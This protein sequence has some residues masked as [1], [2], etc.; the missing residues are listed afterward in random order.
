LNHVIGT[1]AISWAYVISMLNMVVYAMRHCVGTDSARA[2]LYK[3]R[4]YEAASVRS[5]TKSCTGVEGI[6]LAKPRKYLQLLHN[7][8]AARAKR[9][10]GGSSC[11][12]ATGYGLDQN[13]DCVWFALHHTPYSVLKQRIKDISY[14]NSTHTAAELGSLF[15]DMLT[16]IT[17]ELCKLDVLLAN[18]EIDA[19]RST[20][21]SNVVVN[22]QR[23]VSV[24]F[25]NG[26]GTTNTLAWLQKQH[27]PSMKQRVFGGFMSLIMGETSL[28]LEE[29]NYPE[30]VLLDISYIHTARGVFYGQ[31]AQATVLVIIGQ[32]LTDAGING[33]SVNKCLTHLSIDPVF[34]AF[35]LPEA[36]RQT[37]E[38]Q[39]MLHASVCDALNVLSGSTR[40]CDSI[41]D[42]ILWEMGRETTHRAYPTSNIA[43]SIARKWTAA[44]AMAVPNGRGDSPAVFASPETTCDGF[45]SD[46][47]LPNAA[48]F[49]SR[50]FYLSTMTLVNRVV[51]NMAVHSERYRELSHKLTQR[52][53]A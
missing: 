10:G 8:Y 31:V 37:K 30:L 6:L 23:K 44:T 35:G 26:L 13:G 15:C 32:R 53:H 7:T 3:N 34:V 42:L 45:V 40:V 38:T 29:I 16:A 50:E 22:E 27:G 2:V 39:D 24:W 1:G 41:R 17:D 52:A 12:G 47:M 18:A 21:V 28:S 9:S 14:A 46:L 51:F 36:C 19:T 11:D 5:D 33:V 48:V 4:S 43:S 49:L 20:S 25:E